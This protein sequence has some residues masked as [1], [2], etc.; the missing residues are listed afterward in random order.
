MTN[1]P[2]VVPSTMVAFS[3]LAVVELWRFN[4]SLV[5]LEI[6]GLLFSRKAPASLLAVCPVVGDRQ[7]FLHRK[8]EKTLDLH[9]LR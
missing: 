2:R 1:V 9:E 8:P 4:V 7:L 6:P 3:N 5:A